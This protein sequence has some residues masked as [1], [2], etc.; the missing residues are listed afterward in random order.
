METDDFSRGYSH[1]LLTGSGFLLLCALGLHLLSR[2]HSRNSTHNVCA[3]V[4][5]FSVVI[6]AFLFLSG[7]IALSDSCIEGYIS[8]S[9]NETI[10]M[11]YQ[12]RK[13][14]KLQP[15]QLNQLKSSDPQELLKQL[16][17]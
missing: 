17:H 4:A 1:F 14:H 11:S 10:S 5:M 8:R 9:R 13:L 6:A 16:A 3:D 2:K 15:A 12:G 7:L